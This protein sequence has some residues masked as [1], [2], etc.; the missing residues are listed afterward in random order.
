MLAHSFDRFY[1][2][3]KFI[4]PFINDLNLSPIDFDAK[5]SYLNEDLSRYQNEKQYISNLK[6][7]CEKIVPFIDFYKKQISTYNHTAHTVMNEISL[8]LPNFPKDRKKREV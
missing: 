4:L 7:Y 3:T 5:C 6:I 8:T 1:V 2:F